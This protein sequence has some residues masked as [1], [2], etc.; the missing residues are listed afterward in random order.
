MGLLA[1]KAALGQHYYRWLSISGR[2]S[3]LFGSSSMSDLRVCLSIVC[4]QG[5][6]LAFSSL[7]ALFNLVEVGPLFKRERASGLYR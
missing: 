7:S 5:A 6:L 1:L 4:D 2:M 3:F